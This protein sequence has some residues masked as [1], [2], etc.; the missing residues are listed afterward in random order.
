MV[1][2]TAASSGMMGAYLM[3]VVEAVDD[4]GTELVT[5][6]LARIRGSRE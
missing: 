6:R 1:A 2:E 5:R 3:A 4:Y